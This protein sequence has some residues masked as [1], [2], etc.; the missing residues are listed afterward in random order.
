MDVD[1]ERAL[2]T[3]LKDRYTELLNRWKKR[4]GGALSKMRNVGW[5]LIIM[6]LIACQ[7]LTLVMLLDKKSREDKFAEIEEQT[8]L[9]RN[10][11]A[12][13]ELETERLRNQ[14]YHTVL[15]IMEGK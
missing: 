2:L 13:K 4:N 15:N 6:L 9:M 12:A 7:A 5:A 1:L 14:Y 11:A 10:E 3:L 8:L